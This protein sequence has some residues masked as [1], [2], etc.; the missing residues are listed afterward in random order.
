VTPY[1]EQDG[2]TIYHGDCADVIPTLAGVEI[3]LTDP[4]YCP[5]L[6]T[7]K[8]NRIGKPVGYAWHDVEG[9]R[10]VD[11]GLVLSLGLPTVLWGANFFTD[12]LPTHPGWIVWDKQADGFVQGSPCELAWTNYLRNIRLYRRNYRG[13]TAPDKE[14]PTQKPVQLFAWVLRLDETPTG[15]VLDPYMGSG[16][17][18]V[19]AKNL[20]RRA[21]GIEI[22]EQYCEIAAKRLS[23]QVLAL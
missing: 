18:L 15:C 22:E 12:R 5:E 21:I 2:V 19:A 6:D 7:G 20:G 16:T 14:H 3:V 1:Y 9:P 10:G 23:Q 17:T 8:L 11:C 13:F 4:P